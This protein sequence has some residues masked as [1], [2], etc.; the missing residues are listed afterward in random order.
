MTADELRAWRAARGWSLT[1]AATELGLSR[2]HYAYLE[3]GLHS[4]KRPV[5]LACSELARRNASEVAP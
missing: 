4:I 5:E 2:R 1:R 3:S